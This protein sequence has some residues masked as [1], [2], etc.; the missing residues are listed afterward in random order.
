MELFEHCLTTLS[1]MDSSRLG[2]IPETRANVPQ[3]MPD[4]NTDENTRI[5]KASLQDKAK[6]L[7]KLHFFEDK[8]E[9]GNKRENNEDNEEMFNEEYKTL[10]VTGKTGSRISNS[11]HEVQL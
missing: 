7:I 5:E 11:D 1:F 4:M 10:R 3:L 9:R 8:E 2:D 6:Y